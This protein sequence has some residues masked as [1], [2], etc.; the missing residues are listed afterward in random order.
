VNSIN[1]AVGKI[2]DAPHGAK[3]YSVDEQ[4]NINA[5]FHKQF[6]N[7]PLTPQEIAAMHFQLYTQHA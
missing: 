2:G 4:K 5:K 3:Q 7:K 1:L 6:V